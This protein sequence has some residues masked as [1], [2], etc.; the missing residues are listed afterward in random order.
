[1]GQGVHTGGSSQCRRFLPSKRVIDGN[2][3]SYTPVNNR[4]FNMRIG[5]G[6]DAEAGH[7]TGSTGSGVDGDERRHCFAGLVDSS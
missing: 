3:R 1:M 2:V 7:F 5:I 4:H 6:D